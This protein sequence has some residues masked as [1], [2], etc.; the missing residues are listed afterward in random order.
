QPGSQSRGPARR[1]TAAADAFSPLGICAGVSLGLVRTPPGSGV[2]EPGKKGSTAQPARPRPATPIFVPAK[3]EYSRRK[4]KG[5]VARAG[6][7]SLDTLGKWMYGPRF[8]EGRFNY[9]F[10][11]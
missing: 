5:I 3:P 11:A 4:R 8:G 9:I 2:K 1:R 10:F 7:R 6:R